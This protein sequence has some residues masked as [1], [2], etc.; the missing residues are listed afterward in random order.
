MFA[1]GVLGRLSN[2]LLAR[3][4]SA[5]EKMRMN[6]WGNLFAWSSVL[7]SLAGTGCSKDQQSEQALAATAAK[8]IESTLKKPEAAFCEIKFSDGMTSR[9]DPDLALVAGKRV[10]LLCRKSDASAAAQGCW[11]ALQAQKAGFANEK[12]FPECLMIVEG[13]INRTD[14]KTSGLRF[15]C[16]ELSTVSVKKV[17]KL[18]PTRVRVTYALE[19]K[20]EQSKV[21]AIERAC[22][23]VT[24]VP[25]EETAALLLKDGERWTLAGH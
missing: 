16:G 22:G 6:N 4:G 13:R 8:A 9:I 12:S 24:T 11:S 23:E 3:P 2:A 14:D 17:E 21:S 25:S 15:S 20:K 1:L 19:A 5:L 18:E 7:A 10:E